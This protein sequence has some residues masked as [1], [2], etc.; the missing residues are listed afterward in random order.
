VMRSLFCSGQNAWRTIGYVIEEKQNGFI[1]VVYISIPVATDKPTKLHIF[2][3]SLEI[4]QIVLTMST[5][6]PNVVPVLNVSDPR[7]HIS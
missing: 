3:D 2:L 1:H 5:V 6:P 4:D 7:P